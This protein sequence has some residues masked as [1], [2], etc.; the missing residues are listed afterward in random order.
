[1]LSPPA[2]YKDVLVLVDILVLEVIV[3]IRK[4]AAV[5][6]EHKTAVASYGLRKLGVLPNV[7]LE[8]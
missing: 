3:A 2:A 1:M 5:Y 7:R 4:N 6:L 8:S